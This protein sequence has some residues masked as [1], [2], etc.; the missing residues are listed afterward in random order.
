MREADGWGAG[1]GGLRSNLS[2]LW[3]KLLLPGKLAS[4]LPMACMYLFERGYRAAAAA[5]R[6][7]LTA[8]RTQWAERNCRI[9]PIAMRDRQRTQCRLPKFK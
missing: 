1:V 4:W 8:L 5:T 3:K 7:Q 2:M 6:L 9:H